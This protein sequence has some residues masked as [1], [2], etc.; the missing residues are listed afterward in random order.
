MSSKRTLA[1]ALIAGLAALL[2]ACATP[3]QPLILAQPTDPARLAGDWYVI[4]SIPSTWEAGGYDAKESFA[5]RSDGKVDTVYSFHADAGD[6]PLRSYHTVLTPVGQG[7]VV[8]RQHYAWPFDRLVPID[9]D[10]RIAYLSPDAGQAV[11]AREDRDYLLILAR[12]P[13]LAD[14]DYGQLLNF[15]TRIGYDASQIKRVPQSAP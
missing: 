12:S 15:T 2:A 4:A 6:G 7:G 9:R 14:A 11:I 1:T 10:F 8:W 5:P 13:K 3:P